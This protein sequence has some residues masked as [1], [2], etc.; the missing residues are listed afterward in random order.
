M[1]SAKAFDAGT[2][3]SCTVDVELSVDLSLELTQYEPELFPGLIYRMKIPKIVL[4][5]FVSGKVV[6]TGECQA[7]AGAWLPAIV[8]GQ[9]LLS[10][11]ADSVVVSHAVPALP[12]LSRTM[13]CQC[14]CQAARGDL[15]GIRENL[16]SA[17]G[18]PQGRRGC[19]AAAIPRASQPAGDKRHN[20][21]EAKG[22]TCS[23][24]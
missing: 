17:A 15:P 10:L 13:S 23:G 19:S 22:Q 7:C 21:H 11:V 5:V 8:T 18:I 12:A 20:K 3:C 16:P 2:A 9:Q 1:V 24:K 4:L 14:R 6:L